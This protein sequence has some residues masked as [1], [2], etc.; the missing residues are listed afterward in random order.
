MIL[1]ADCGNSRTKW[2]LY[3]QQKL[4]STGVVGENESLEESLFTRDIVPGQLKNFV[5]SSVAP[6]K[7]EPLKK[8]LQRLTGGQ[9]GLELCGRNVPEFSHRYTSLQELG[10][11]RIAAALGAMD[12]CPGENL[13]IADFG[14]AITLDALSAEGVFLGGVIMPGLASALKG[15]LDSA[16][17]LLSAG[18]G[19]D[20]LS[21]KNWAH[22][23][24]GCNTR[25]A[26]QGGLFCLTLGAV[27]EAR[28]R[29]TRSCFAGIPAYLLVTGGAGQVF[30]EELPRSFYCEDLLFRGLARF[31]EIRKGKTLC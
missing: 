22:R 15:L 23:V 30:A 1:L 13:L 29:L 8:E 9:E 16:P 26:L 10:S 11:D 6:A 19:T 28:E 31:Y 2:A 3:D 18:L 12:V 24:P 7:T 17:G 27:K 14:T 25:G 21:Q 4:G 20:A 5:F